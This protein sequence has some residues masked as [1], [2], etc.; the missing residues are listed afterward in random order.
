[1]EEIV[2]EQNALL[3]VIRK[4]EPIEEYNKL[5]YVLKNE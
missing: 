4:K 5:D 3:R 2:K 1:M